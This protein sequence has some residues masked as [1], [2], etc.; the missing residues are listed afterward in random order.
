MPP[1]DNVAHPKALENALRGGRLTIV[2][3]RAAERARSCVVALLEV[4]IDPKVDR[5]MIVPLPKSNADHMPIVQGLPT[6]S[7]N[8]LK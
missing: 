3:E 6:C 5:K 8:R 2:L 4:P 1:S 7:E